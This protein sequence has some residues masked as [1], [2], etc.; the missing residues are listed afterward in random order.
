MS[1]ANAA[2]RATMHGRE[3]QSMSAIVIKERPVAV[4]G[5]FEKGVKYTVGPQTFVAFPSRSSN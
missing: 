2:E 4:G 3:Q 5:E 1:S